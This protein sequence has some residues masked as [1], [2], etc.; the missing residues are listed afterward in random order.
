M[1][2]ETAVK[3]EDESMKKIM[4]WLMAGLFGVFLGLITLASNV[5]A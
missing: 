3:N 5:A 2:M 1:D 4:I